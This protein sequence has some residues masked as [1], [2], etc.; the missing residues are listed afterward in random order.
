MPTHRQ[1]TSA[2]AGTP[3]RRS[4][5]P[6]GRSARA[7]RRRAGPGRT[8]RPA[9]RA[10]TTRTPISSPSSSSSSR[11]VSIRSGDSRGDARARR[12]ILILDVVTRHTS[13]PLVPR[14]TRR[15]RRVLLPL[16]PSSP[17]TSP[18]RSGRTSCST[19]SSCTIGPQHRIGVVA[20][21]GTGKTT[22]LRILAG[23]DA[24]DSG[25]RHAHAADRDR[26]LPPAGARTARRARPCARTSPAAPASPAPSTR[27][28]HA[29]DRARR[30]ARR[31]P[32]TRTRDALER[33]LAL[34]AADFDARIGAVLADLGLPERVLDLD[35]TGALGRAGGAREPRRDPARPLRRVP[36]RRADERPRLRRPRPARAVPPRRPRG[37]RG[38]RVARPRV[39]RPHDHE[40]ARARRARAHRHRVRR[41]L[42]GVPR[43]A[44]DRAP[45]RRGGLR[46]RTTRSAATLRDRAQ[47]AAAVVG[48]GQGEG[49]KKRRD[50]QVHPALPAQQQRA[51]RGQGED[52]RPGARTARGE[53]G[54]QAVGGLGP[55]HGDRD[56][57]PQRRRRR[58]ARRR[59]RRPRRRSR[60]GRSTSQID[61][62]ERVALLGANGSGKTT[63]L[64][65]DRSAG[66][67]STRASARLGPGVV[68]GELDQ[69]RAAFAGADAA[70]RPLRGRERAAAERGAVAAREVRARRRARRPAPA[71]S[72]SPGERT[73]ASLALLSARGRELPRARRA[74]EPPRPPRD[75]AARAGARRTSRARCC[76]SPTTARCSTRSR[77]PAAS[78]STTAGSRRRSG[79]SAIT[80]LG[81]ERDRG[82]G[83]DVQRVDAGLHRDPHA[84]RRPPRATRRDSPGPRRRAAARTR[85]GHSTSSSGAASAAGVSANERE[86]RGRA[87]SSSDAIRVHGT[88]QH[89]PDRDPHAAPVE[90]IGASRR[91]AARRRC[92]T[93]PRCGTAPPRF[94]WSLTCSS[95]ATRR[96][97]S[98][99]VADRRQRPAIARRDRAPVQV[100]ADHP[101]QHLVGRRRT[102]ARRAPLERR[103]PAPSCCAGVTSTDRTP[104]A[105]FAAAPRTTSGDSAMKKPRSA[106]TRRRSCGSARPT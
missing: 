89:V 30:P 63:L 92:R 77:S 40:R 79:R 13:E 104:S 90:R 74:D 3:P 49:R 36:A 8:S 66:S 54:R 33:Y 68:V 20:P 100:E 25:T 59:G 84:A 81:V 51:R 27:S 62:G 11:D 55:P 88:R 99:T 83:R 21:N 17:A 35:M 7:R 43:R 15:C 56:R 57:A 70:P 102:P 26:R 105:R 45:P 4:R 86:A 101:A 42:A 46:R 9:W 65:A 18:S 38:D 47:R 64:D 34:G 87:R 32:T 44:G 67:R 72:L 73:R 28:T 82:R 98:S 106:S 19:A 71:D 48:A 103:R 1:S 24:P 52:H 75:R 16:P 37:R 29:S 95:T 31:A 5:S 80:V 94:S 78:S 41:R 91:R 6:R 14:S 60:S 2:P 10:P 53:R 50:R 39:P 76:S 85:S 12:A 58:P 93:R 97:P 61:Y 69:A 23:L 96:A 22:L